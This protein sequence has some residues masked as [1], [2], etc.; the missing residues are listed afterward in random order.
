MTT[1]ET[2]RQLEAAMAAQLEARTALEKAGPTLIGAMQEA[3]LLVDDAMLALSRVEGAIVAAEKAERDDGPPPPPPPGPVLPGQQAPRH[4]RIREFNVSG[5]VRIAPDME[6]VEVIVGRHGPDTS[7]L[8]EPGDYKI[9][10][11]RPLRG[12]TILSRGGAART[13]FY[14][15]GGGYG[16]RAPNPHQHD[17]TIG[18]FTFEGFAEHPW[19]ALPAMVSPRW[20][21]TLFRTNEPDWYGGQCT[22][23]V[24]HDSVLKGNYRAVNGFSMGNNGAMIRCQANGFTKTA[25]GVDRVSGG[26]LVDSCQFTGNGVDAATG[27]YAN[28]AD[29]KLVFVNGYEGMYQVEPPELLPDRAEFLVT[30]SVFRAKDENGK[31]SE[32]G[33]WGDLDTQLLRAAKNEF[34]GYGYGGLVFELSSLVI[35]EDNLFQDCAGYGQSLGEDFIIGALTF[36]ETCWGIAR[37]N[38]F[39][40]CGVP[41]VVRCSNRTYD[42]LRPTERPYDINYAWQ[43]NEAARRY[44]ISNNYRAVNP[45]GTKSNLATAEIDIENNDFDGGRVVINAGSLRNG[46]DVQTAMRS[47][48]GTIRFRGNTWGPGMRFSELER[49]N[50]TYDAWTTWGQERGYARG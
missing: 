2:L 24:L 32:I 15:E 25:F 12:M 20:A 49:F 17:V 50:L 28:G 13:R 47:L 11:V 39:V 19:N 8:V 23:W 45:K 43:Q 31:G 27:A 41:L 6:P 10:D 29:G 1:E 42:M 40:R 30:N 9:S 3:A 38:R 14:G 48:L 46:Q 21:D 33:L 16:I 5:A 26:G 34:H 44:W 7:F 18:G 35:A 22:G 37:R 4:P 36:G